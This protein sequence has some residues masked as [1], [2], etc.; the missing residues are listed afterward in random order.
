MNS[1]LLAYVAVKNLLL[2]SFYFYFVSKQVQKSRERADRE[3]TVP[4][5]S[6]TK[7]KSKSATSEHLR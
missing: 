5:V 1:T 2:T 3:E 7:M 6:S 4:V